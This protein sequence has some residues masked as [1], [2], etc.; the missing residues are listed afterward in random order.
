MSFTQRLCIPRRISTHTTYHAFPNQQLKGTSALPHAQ[1]ADLHDRA[2]RWGGSYRIHRAHNTNP[3]NTFS[4]SSDEDNDVA[5]LYRI[6]DTARQWLNCAIPY[7]CRLSLPLA[8]ER[9]KAIRASERHP[10]LR[11]QHVVFVWG[12][13]AETNLYTFCWNTGGLGFTSV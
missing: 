7:A 1:R 4:T 13:A 8:T 11:Q 3:L 9:D 6:A 5:H 12:N 2:S 10:N